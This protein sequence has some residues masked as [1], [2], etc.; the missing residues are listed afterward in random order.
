M[1]C[2]V[3]NEN[4]SVSVRAKHKAQHNTEKQ[5]Q[6]GLEKRRVSKNK[7]TENKKKQ[8]RKTG[9][10]VFSLKRPVLKESNKVLL[11]GKC[12]LSLEVNGGSCQKRK[13][14]N[15]IVKLQVVR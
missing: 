9:Y 12:F 2:L 15:E 8:R 3:C 6:K 14:R 1:W 10:Q 4:I 11:T 7:K 13:M 5:F